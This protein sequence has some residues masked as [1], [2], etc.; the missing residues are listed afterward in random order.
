VI[1]PIDTLRRGQPMSSTLGRIEDLPL[2]YREGLRSRN[3]MPLWPSLRAALPYGKPTRSTTPTLWR[4]RELRPDLMRAGEL[5]PIEK[6]E[7]RVLVLCNPGLGL[8]QLKATPSI[9]VGLQLILPGETAPNHLH[10]P[11]AVRFVIEGEGGYTVVRGEKLPM[12]RGDLILTPAGLWHQHGHEGQGPVVWLD[13]LDLPVVYGLEAS[14]CT[15]GPPQSVVD[16]DSPA[17]RRFRQAGVLPYGTLDRARADYPMLR[18]P[19]SRVREALLDLASVTAAADAVHLA[20]V[21]PETGRECMPTLGFSALMLRPG[22]ELRMRRRSASAVLH[23]VD[24][25]ASAFVDD[26]RHA[27]EPADTLACPTHAEVVLANASASH[28]AFLFMVDDAPLQRK[29]GFFEQFA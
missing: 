9:Y 26:S 6:A 17:S 24:G 19:W 20:Y 16:A 13:A 15:E 12:H 3:L 5:T 8:E 2:D 1:T 7:R 18:F 22:E 11:S 14:Y 28:P 10:T 29:L 4:Y 27:L 23:V 21:N 25:S